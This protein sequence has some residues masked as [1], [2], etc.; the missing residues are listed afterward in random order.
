MEMLESFQRGD[1]LVSDGPCFAQLRPRRHGH[2]RR[3]S[4]NVLTRSLFSAVQHEA[5]VELPGGKLSWDNEKHRTKVFHLSEI[6]SPSLQSIPA[7]QLTRVGF[8][9][10][11]QSTCTSNITT[12]GAE[13]HCLRYMFSMRIC[14]V[15]AHSLP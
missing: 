6:S 2:A 4:M 3:L 14:L 9:C 13:C 15:L 1:N 7:T 10:A 11:I 12:I 5:R 8:D